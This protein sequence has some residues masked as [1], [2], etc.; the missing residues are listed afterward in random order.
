MFDI[1][2][3]INLFISVIEVEDPLKTSSKRTHF[4]LPIYFFN[5]SRIPIKNIK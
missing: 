1:P 2:F 5:V 4:A 3:N